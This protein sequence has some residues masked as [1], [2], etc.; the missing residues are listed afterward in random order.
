MSA[1]TKQI[2]PIWN[3]LLYNALTFEPNMQN[4]DIFVIP[5][6]KYI[7]VQYSLY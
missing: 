7:Y 2:P 5:K 3:P 4:L 1:T 6:K